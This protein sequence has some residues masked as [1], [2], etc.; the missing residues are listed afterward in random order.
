MLPS[1]ND[2]AYVLAENFGY[3]HKIHNKNLNEQIE[4]LRYRNI[5]SNMKEDNSDIIDCSKKF[6]NLMN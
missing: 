3:I 1:G 2:A 5:M 4:N 6:L